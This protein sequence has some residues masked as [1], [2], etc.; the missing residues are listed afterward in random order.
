MFSQVV[1]AETQSF[2]SDQSLNAFLD[3]KTKIEEILN[4]LKCG[5]VVV[6]N[7]IG[8]SDLKEYFHQFAHQVDAIIKNELPLCR[9]AGNDRDA[10]R[11]VKRIL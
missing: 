8:E 2:D 10:L 9:S 6:G 7:V 1:F 11:C 4:L 3:V 5:R